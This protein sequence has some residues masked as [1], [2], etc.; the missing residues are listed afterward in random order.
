M[1]G[2]IVGAVAAVL[3]VLLI[4]RAVRIVPQSHAS[5]VERLGRFQRTLG[6]GIH[7]VIPFVDK[8]RPRID[9]REQVVSFDPQSVITEDNL[10]VYIDTVIYFQVTDPQAAQYEIASYIK[11]IEQL[12]TTTLRN[13]IGGMA[14]EMTLTSRDTINA[15]LRG[16][17]DEATGKWGIRVNRVEVKA[18]DPPPTIREAMEKQ[19]RA[20]RDKRAAILTA[21]GAR[22]SAILTAEGEKQ[23]SILRAEG[24]RES[25]ILT[26]AGQAG[27]IETVFAAV[28]AG[29]PSPAI[30][31]YQYLQTLPQLAREGNT[32]L[33]IPSE[34][35]S[36]MET[37]RKAF[38]QPDSGRPTT[39][40][41]PTKPGTP[42]TDAGKGPGP[43]D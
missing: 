23:S 3:I 7:V 41:T 33:V 30:L 4:V 11:A 38:D 31:A 43:A 32:F 18:I 36:A 1:T 17:L 37:V 20:E 42:S 29:N 35:T 40:G 10:V 8:V 26:A 14:L 24:D 21:E 25:R 6:A 12:T 16:V 9:L 34:L 19:M 13:V 2:F 5:N 15:G 27:A 28:H 39:P 22:Q